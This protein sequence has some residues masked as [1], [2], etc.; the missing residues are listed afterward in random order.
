MHRDDATL[1]D[2][3]SAANRAVAY[4]AGIEKSA[5]LND[6][7]K[8]SAILYQVIVLGEATKRL[9]PEFCSQHPEIPWKDMAGMRD[10]LVH[11]YDCISFNT[12]WDVI[13]QDIPQLL[14]LLVPLLPNAQS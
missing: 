5:L 12:L 13:Q 4:A 7:E 8:Q 3:A 6:D 14:S 2:I 11:Q 10:I 9:S 1:L